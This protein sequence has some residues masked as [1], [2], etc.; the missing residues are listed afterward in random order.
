V[1]K[2]AIFSESF[3]TWQSSS[4]T[5]SQTNKFQQIFWK[6]VK[7]RSLYTVHCSRS[8]SEP[9]LRGLCGLCHQLLLVRRPGVFPARFLQQLSVSPDLLSPLWSTV[10]SVTME[11]F[12]WAG[13]L[14]CIVSCSTPYFLILSR[15]NA[16]L[17]M[18][19]VK[20]R[21]P[22]TTSKSLNDLGFLQEFKWKK[23]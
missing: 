10:Q 3:C 8:F 18:S 23:Q 11:G 19:G 9:L 2:H 20:L 22:R 6:S 13:P 7:L 16:F 1:A 15:R 21:S 5:R 14:C 12:R 17:S 4:S